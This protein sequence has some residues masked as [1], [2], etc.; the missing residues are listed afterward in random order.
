MRPPASELAG[1]IAVTTE[2]IGPE[3]TGKITVLSGDGAFPAFARNRPGGSY[4]PAGTA[5]R[6]V[7]AISDTLVVIKRLA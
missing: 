4:I 5:V 7:E 2:P 6:I 3:G 1:M